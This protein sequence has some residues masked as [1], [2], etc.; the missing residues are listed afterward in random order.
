[1]INSSNPMTEILPAERQKL[2]LLRCSLDLANKP[3][4]YDARLNFSVQL[5]RSGHQKQ[6]L[7]HM[8]ALV[9]QFPTHLT[10]IF[11]LGV[12]LQKLLRFSEAASVYAR[13]LKINPSYVDAWINMAG[14]CSKF[15]Y[16]DK[17]RAAWKRV[18]ILQPDNEMAKHMFLALSNSQPTIQD[19]NQNICSSSSQMPI[20][21]IEGIFD[22]YAAHFDDHLEQEL[23]Y[24]TPKELISL[25]QTNEVKRFGLDLG[26]GTGLSGI[27]IR[28]YVEH[29]VGSDISEKM[30]RQAGQKNIYDQLWHLDNEHAL[31]R[32]ASLGLLWDMVT[33][34][35]VFP[36]AGDLDAIFNLVSSL[37]VPKGAFLFSVEAVGLCAKPYRLLPTGR[38]AHSLNY[39]RDRLPQYKFSIE[40]IKAAP[41]RRHR[42]G[43]IDG[44]LV[45][46]KKR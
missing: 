26:C 1:M 9:R 16:N 40:K 22:E 8:T 33:A 11:N 35:D 20:S 15:G 17:S 31:K 19:E 24:R 4:D 13:V 25:L 28:S 45:H 32:A 2:Q 6:G 38:Y 43:L 30:L 44:Y 7:Q 41:I 46:C 12:M 23:D 5:F 14:I 39:L 29:L 37:L 18:L 36:Y 34:I 10:A 27:E 21:M 42:D 3:E